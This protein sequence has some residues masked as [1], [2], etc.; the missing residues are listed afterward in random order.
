MTAPYSRPAPSGR[1][2][3]DQAGVSRAIRHCVSSATAGHWAA[4]QVRPEV[5]LGRD[6]RSPGGSRTG[7]VPATRTGQRAGRQGLVA[8]WGIGTT[9][10]ATDLAVGCGRPGWRSAWRGRAAAA[11]RGLV[12]GWVVGTTASATN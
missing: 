4:G 10:L 7:A 6:R 11:P 2:S 1:Q 12:A 9:V 5:T 3:L 8:A